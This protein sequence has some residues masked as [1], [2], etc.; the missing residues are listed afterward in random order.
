MHP[1]DTSGH[2]GGWTEEYTTKAHE[3]AYLDKSPSGSAKGV[4]QLTSFGV[5]FKD[6]NL[7]KK[8]LIKNCTKT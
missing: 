4:E 8:N 7:G 3:G 6:T 1:M 2:T 5:M